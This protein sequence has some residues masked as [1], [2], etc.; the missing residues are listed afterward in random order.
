[1]V[2]STQKDFYQ[3]YQDRLKGVRM[4]SASVLNVDMWQRGQI[5]AERELVEQ[6]EDEKYLLQGCDE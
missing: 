1:M 4:P 2:F 5:A 6:E 3:G